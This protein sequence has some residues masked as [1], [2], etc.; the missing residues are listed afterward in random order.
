MNCDYRTCRQGGWADCWMLSALCSLGFHRP[1]EL[2]AMLKPNG[3]GSFDV[4]LPDKPTVTVRPEQGG[5]TA[6]EGEWAAAIEAAVT[7]FTDAAA[8]RVLSF[9]EGITMLTGRRR[10]GYTN[11][12]GAGFAPLTRLRRRREWFENRVHTATSNSRV[13][14]LGGSDGY[15][16]DV[17]VEG[18][19]NRHCY[20]L[21]LFEPDF[22]TCRI[23]DPRGLDDAIPQG[24]KRDGYGPGE[25]WLTSA[26]VESSYC[27]LSLEN[28]G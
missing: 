26:E 24:R 20:S 5:G 19:I 3:D 16:T 11:V 12:T 25:F 15:W 2:A 4:T 10:T 17:K 18:L 22:G 7:Q 1:A 27:G 9:G 8:D 23:R 28:E 14:I 21:L 6:S 13:V